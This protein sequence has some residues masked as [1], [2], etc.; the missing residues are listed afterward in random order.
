MPQPFATMAL[1]VAATARRAGS[2]P[3]AIASLSAVRIA[4]HY[5]HKAFQP[6]RNDICTRRNGQGLDCD[7]AAGSRAAAKLE[8]IRREIDAIDARYPPGFLSSPNVRPP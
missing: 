5:D 7:S 3:I 6:R 2:A 1:L 8:R 4:N